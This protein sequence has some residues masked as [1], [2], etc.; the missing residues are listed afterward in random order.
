MKE[1]SFYEALSFGT[2]RIV[3]SL[4]DGG[5]STGTGFFVYLNKIENKEEEPRPV[6]ITNKHVIKGAE[7][8][9]LTLST[10]KDNKI[11]G[12]EKIEIPFSNF[13]SFWIPHPDDSID[14]CI[15]NFITIEGRIK[16]S[17]NLDLFYLPLAIEMIPSITTMVTFDTMEEVV[18][19]GY[20]NGIWDSHNNKP[21][22]RKGV[23]ATDIRLD[24]E[25]RPEFLIDM[26]VFG[27]SSGSPI[28]YAK[29][30]LTP[31]MGAVANHR[32]LYLLGILYA[33]FQ[34]TASGDVKII[35][36]PQIQKTIIETSIPNNLGI[37][38]KSE[39]LIDFR[40]MYFND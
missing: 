33:G 6:L 3:C 20:P 31:Y 27:G 22:F 1:L 30:K 16:S 5:T 29:D 25:Q 9:Y 11:A 40:R 17:L 34:H 32:K 36:I 28:L 4:K 23:T 26:A 10:M 19:I 2:T 13:E 37:A 12:T 35:E 39:K 18:M 15:L 38:I 8:G 21:I 24:Y 14:L 7:R